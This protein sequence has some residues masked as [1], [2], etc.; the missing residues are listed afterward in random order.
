MKRIIFSLTLILTGFVATAQNAQYYKAMGAAL[1]QFP[2]CKT[3]ADYQALSNRFDMI[4]N[5]EK[6]QWLPRYYQAQCYI[7]MSFAEKDVAKKDGYL[8]EA[9]KIVNQLIKTEPKEAEV[10]VL[11]SFYYTARLVVNPA[12]RGQQFS[13]L[14]G[15]AIGKAL[16]LEPNN[17]R[18][19]MMKIQM[20]MGTARFF[21]TDPKVYCSAAKKLLAH[22][23]QYQPKSPLYPNWGK[24]QLENIVKGCQ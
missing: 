19:K 12:E 20:D 24:R 15:Q 3:V 5:A 7:L 14:S 13:Q 11:Q 21:G 9:E 22:W 2:T 8:D 10:Y 23:D 4:A 6:G 1:S 18:A 17:P 16:A